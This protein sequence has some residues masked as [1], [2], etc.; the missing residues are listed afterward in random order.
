MYRRIGS[1]SIQNSLNTWARREELKHVATLPTTTNSSKHSSF[2]NKIHKQIQKHTF[3]Y[4]H[5]KVIKKLCL[6]GLG[7][8]LWSLNSNLITFSLSVWKYSTIHVNPYG[9]EV[10]E[11]SPLLPHTL[12][13]FFPLKKKSLEAKQN[14]PESKNVFLIG[15]FSLK[16]GK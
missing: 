6:K 2:M 14:Y 11:R 1:E 12:G 3:M 15:D 7:T 9:V 10:N 5:Q 13:G 8:N 4:C 16:D